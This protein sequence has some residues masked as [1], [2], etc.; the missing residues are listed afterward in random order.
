MTCQSPKTSTYQQFTITKDIKKAKEQGGWAGGPLSPLPPLIPLTFADHA[1]ETNTIL[2]QG[3]EFYVLLWNCAKT[4]SRKFSLF[5]P[6]I[7][8]IGFPLFQPSL[9]NF[10]IPTM[11]FTILMTF[12]MWAVPVTNKIRQVSVVCRVGRGE[13]PLMKTS[14]D[15]CLKLNKVIS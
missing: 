13:L 11:Y 10:T 9:T 1:A 4:E 2:A 3:T 12:R 8:M 5:P 14:L 7:G 6:K 15:K